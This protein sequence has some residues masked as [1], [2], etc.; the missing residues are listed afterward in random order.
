LPNSVIIEFGVVNNIFA[1][2]LLI[3]AL[4]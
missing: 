1:F 4:D 2:Q 3:K